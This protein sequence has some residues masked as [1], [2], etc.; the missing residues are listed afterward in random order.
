[1]KKIKNEGY[2]LKGK[3]QQWVEKK[4]GSGKKFSSEFLENL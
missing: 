2:I 1:M 4:S 3:E